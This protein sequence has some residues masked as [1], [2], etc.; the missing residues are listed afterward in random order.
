[1]V[2]RS[3][4]Y[5][6][7]NHPRHAA[8]ALAGTADAAVLDLED[9]VAEDQKAAARQALPELLERRPA[10]GP[11]VFVRVNGLRTGH[12]HQDLLAAVLPQVRG[13][14]VPKVE[15]ASEVAIADWMLTQLESERGR[16][17]G[18]VE[19]VPLVETAAGLG[20]LPEICAASPRV[21]RVSFGAADFAL[22]VGMTL[23]AGAGEGVLAAKLRVLVASRAAGLDPPLD[24]VY[25]NF[26]D[27]DGF[28][29]EAEQ[30]RRLG[31]MG[32]TCIHPAQV[33]LANRVFTPTEDEVSQALRTLRAFDDALAEGSASVQLDGR[34]IDYPIAERA[35]RLVE[36][37]DRI[38]GRST[39]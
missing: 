26:R 36:L 31:F 5:A 34:M 30:A 6:P 2:L 27:P 10:G 21:R 38:S 14:L 25:P 9:A 11:A 4:L 39:R 22:D 12:A 19:L 37:A 33:E 32:K 8:G 7:A 15:S 28:L 20:R 1:M 24:V 29:R 18:A 16:D 35:R 3:M 17:S 23:G 13:V